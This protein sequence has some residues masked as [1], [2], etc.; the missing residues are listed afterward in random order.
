MTACYN[1]SV[2]CTGQGMVAQVVFKVLRKE[3]VD[4]ETIIYSRI[5]P[6]FFFEN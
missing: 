6:G 1:V 5:K 4:G 2:S 3:E